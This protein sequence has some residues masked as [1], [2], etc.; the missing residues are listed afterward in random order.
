MVVVLQVKETIA[1]LAEQVR[2]ASSDLQP[3]LERLTDEA[4]QLDSKVSLSQLVIGRGAETYLMDEPVPACS[5]NACV[6]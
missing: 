2:N 4:M 1:A 3:F 5:R 6:A